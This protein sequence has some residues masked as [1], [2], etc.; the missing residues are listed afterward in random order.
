MA[1]VK[2]GQVVMWFYVR[3]PDDAK[4]FY[5]RLIIPPEEQDNNG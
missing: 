3:S 1:P 5:S 2:E 4:K